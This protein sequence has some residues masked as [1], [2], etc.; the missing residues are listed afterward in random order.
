MGAILRLVKQSP[1]IGGLIVTCHGAK[2]AYNQIQMLLLGYKIHSLLRTAR[3]N[4]QVEGCVYQRKKIR[5]R[6]HQ[7]QDRME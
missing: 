7:S 6:N 1:R 5:H 3:N 4:R 2:C